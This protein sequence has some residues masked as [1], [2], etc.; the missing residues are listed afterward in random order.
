MTYLPV[1]AT[2]SIAR[3]ENVR[4]RPGG[5]GIA[6]SI[7]SNPNRARVANGCRVRPIPRLKRTD[8]PKTLLAYLFWRVCQVKSSANCRPCS[9][10]A[11]SGGVWYRAEDKGT[12]DPEGDD[13]IY[14]PSRPGC[15]SRG[16]GRGS[17]GRSDPRAHQNP[18]DRVAL[19]GLPQQV[20]QT[21]Q[22][23]ARGGGR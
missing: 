20:D 12:R 18:V 21:S 22:T 19:P 7:R 8:S 2:G 13:A 15:D 4:R 17:R 1:S 10:L 9:A 23:S 6:L 5:K 14:D 3:G 11:P 16:N